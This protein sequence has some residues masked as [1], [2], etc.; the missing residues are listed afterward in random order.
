MFDDESELTDEA[1][2]LL[3]RKL[4]RLHPDAH[5]DLVRRLPDGARV[6]L[7]MAENR[8]DSRRDTRG[9]LKWPDDDLDSEVIAPIGDDAAGVLARAEKVRARL[10]EIGKWAEQVCSDGDFEEK[11]VAG[12]TTQVGRPEDQ[13]RITAKGLVKVLSRLAEGCRDGAAASKVFAERFQ[14]QYVDPVEEAQKRRPDSGQ[15]L[16]VN[17]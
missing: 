16:K 13:A 9:P 5:A 3:T 7:I 17:R 12:L 15:G 1:V 8:A 2:L 4:G 14:G 10:A 11:V 6:A